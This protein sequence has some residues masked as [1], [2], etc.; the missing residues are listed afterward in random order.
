MTT[1]FDEYEDTAENRA[2]ILTPPVTPGRDHIRGNSDAPVTL[3][4][5]GD[6]EC[7]YSGTAYPIVR[8][9]EEALGDGLRVAFRHFPLANIHPHAVQAGEAAE[10]AGAQGRFWEMHDHLFENQSAL[11]LRHL[12]GYARATGLDVDRF[13]RELDSGVH[14]PRVR[15]DFLS[16]V[17][18]GVRGT[19][20]FFINGV[21]HEGPWDFESLLAALA[22]AVPATAGRA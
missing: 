19:P 6:F 20:T 15:E 11:D 12:V 21:R 8:A 3:T 16:G 17:R 10:A 18:S 22:R 14:A 2:G 4:E 5:Y 1:G 13:L 7:P 9:L